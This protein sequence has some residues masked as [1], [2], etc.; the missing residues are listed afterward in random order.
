MTAEEKEGRRRM[1]V[2]G[3]GGVYKN[4]CTPPTPLAISLVQAVINLCSDRRL[5]A[6]NFRLTRGRQRQGALP[7]LPPL[8]AYIH[9]LQL[10]LAHWRCGQEAVAVVVVVVVGGGGGYYVHQQG[11]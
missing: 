3:G 4:S 8:H 11:S 10:T 1:A 9:H 7:L 2:R 5:G 6:G